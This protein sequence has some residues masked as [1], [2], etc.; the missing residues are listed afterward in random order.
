MVRI[1]MG[2]QDHVRTKRM[3]DAR[4]PKDTGNNKTR[5]ALPGTAESSGPAS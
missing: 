3:S 2:T 5:S 1:T 4:I